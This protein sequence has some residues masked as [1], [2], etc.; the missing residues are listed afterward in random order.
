[1]STVKVRFAILG[2]VLCLMLLAGLA[3]AGGSGVAAATPVEQMPSSAPAARPEAPLASIT[4]T[5]VYHELPLPGLDGVIAG[6]MDLSADGTRIAFVGGYDPNTIYVIEANGRNLR[7]VDSYT[8]S[9]NADSSVDLSGDGSKV[10][11]WDGGTIL[12]LANAD[13]GGAHQVIAI[14]GGY[15]DFHLSAD[16]SRITFVVDRDW[17]LQP[18]NQVKKAGVY[19]VNGDGSNLKQLVTAEQ[20]ATLFGTTPADFPFSGGPGR[21]I[22]V[23]DDGQRIVFMAQVRD[24]GPT[25]FR[26]G[27]DGGGL[28]AYDLYR[29]EY[30]WRVDNVRI[31]GD[32]GTVLYTVAPNPC[33]STPIEWGVVNY[34]GS[35][36]RTLFTGYGDASYARSVALTQNGALLSVP[37]YGRLV[38]T[39][40]S[41]EKLDLA[42]WGGLPTYY[43]EPIIDGYCLT[44]NADGTRFAYLDW[45]GGYG[46]PKLGTL[47]INPPS[48]GP[49]PRI[50]NVL[51]TPVYL[52]T[53]G[54]SEA[55]ITARVAAAS[56]PVRVG[57]VALLNNLQDRTIIEGVLVDNGGTGDAKAGDGIY[58]AS[59]IRTTAD[60][61]TTGPRTM[62]V[63]ADVVALDG[64]RHSTA[65]DVVAFD[66]RADHPS[67][68]ISPETGGALNYVDGRGNATVIS[69][70]PWAFNVPTVLWLI[71][72]PG[73]TPPNERATQRAFE[74]LARQGG[75]VIS[76]PNKAVTVTIEYADEEIAG[77]DEAK[78]RLKRFVEGGNQWVEAGCGPYVRQLE[79]NTLTVPLCH[80]SRF[81]L[82]EDAT[83]QLF[84]PVVQRP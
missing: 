45:T 71:P 81:G 33:C 38:K 67:A 29:D 17:T 69:V 14:E 59:P 35:D 39:D 41:G 22:D 27:A 5:L 8:P 65:V 34:D 20:I 58:T 2:T 78:L 56:S 7:Q 11:S 32:G 10:L 12:R 42:L 66:V 57:S 82:F 44:M 26:V 83:Q 23:S 77:L 30:Y 46:H 75:V 4:R 51:M 79:E 84:L 49:A 53:E 48:L 80:F 72:L 18:G 24:H 50:D 68:T 25:L 70:P 21:W 31:S 16:G 52:L 54:R 19:T 63:V 37:W 28:H 76:T 13:G 6:R 3:V 43:A 73:V 40:G 55:K 15:K 60:A 62:R 1:M 36:R 47:T 64:T 61:V 74:L 9:G